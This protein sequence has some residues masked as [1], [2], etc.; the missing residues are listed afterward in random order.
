MTG[1]CDETRIDMSVISDVIASVG[2]V[3]FHVIKA[4]CTVIIILVGVVMVH[5][6]VVV[7]AAAY[8]IAYQV[9]PALFNGRRFAA[10]I[11]SIV[12]WL[13]ILILHFG[14]LVDVI[15]VR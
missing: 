11:A 12:H 15:H 10:N 13:W 14:K 6:A 5:G 9:C 4:R 8:S 3:L 2:N 7:A 1:A